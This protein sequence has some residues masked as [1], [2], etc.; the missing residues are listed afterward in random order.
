MTLPYPTSVV[1]LGVDF[2]KSNSGFSIVTSDG[3]FNDFVC[4]LIIDLVLLGNDVF[5]IL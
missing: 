3:I 2:V 5:G 4:N 1:L